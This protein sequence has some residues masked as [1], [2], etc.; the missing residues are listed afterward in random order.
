M[1]HGSYTKI[2]TC[3]VDRVG[4]AQNG[5]RPSHN[6]K[7]IQVILTIGRETRSQAGVDS[8]RSTTQVGP[9]IIYKVEMQ[10]EC[11]VSK[12]CRNLMQ[13]N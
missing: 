1:Y 9:M 3:A 8:S 13:T 7:M 5:F 10:G 12:H 11:T 6:G 2:P 4:T